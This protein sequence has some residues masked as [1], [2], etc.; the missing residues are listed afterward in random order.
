MHLL[1]NTNSNLVCNVWTSS[2]HA[3]KNCRHS[4]MQ[5]FHV[6]RLGHLLRPRGNVRSPAVEPASAATSSFN[7]AESS[8][9][10]TDQVAGRTVCARAQDANTSVAIP[11]T[12]W[13]VRSPTTLSEMLPVLRAK[14]AASQHS[15]RLQCCR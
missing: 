9:A 12:P 13:Q 14:A 3:G 15:G 11:D 5:P 10:C 2:W 4:H 6:L 1:C 7:A 8:T